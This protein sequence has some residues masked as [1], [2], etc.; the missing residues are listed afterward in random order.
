MDQK[1]VEEIFLSYRE[2][3]LR[4]RQDPNFE[5]IIIFKNHGKAAGTSLVHPHSQVIA[6]PVTPTH[7]R[8]RLEKAMNYYD[9]EGTCVYCDMIREEKKAEARI[10]METENFICFEPFAARSPFETY[11]LPKDH[12]SSFG[13]ISADHT[14]ELAYIMRIVLLKI[15]KSLNNPD[16]NFIISS[17]PLREPSE[18]YYHWHVRIVPRVSAVAGFEM[19]SGIYINTVL[20]EDA[21]EFLR[22]TSV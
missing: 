13:V 19:G 20:P 8:Y 14:R 15:H 1:Q 22:N 5:I 9:D 11:V 6:A 16:Y 18:E 3:Y 4:L 12:R 7:I 17:S 2:S 21:A 10:V